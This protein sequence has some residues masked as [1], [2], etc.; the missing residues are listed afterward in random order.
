MKKAALL[1][2]VV[3][4]FSFSHAYANKIEDLNKTLR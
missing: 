3:V 4:L 1:V 2:A